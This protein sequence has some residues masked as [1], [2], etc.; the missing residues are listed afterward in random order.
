MLNANRSIAAY[1]SRGIAAFYEIGV[2]DGEDFEP[3][4]QG[5]GVPTQCSS[6]LTTCP[7]HCC[8]GH[9]ES[10]S[11]HRFRVIQMMTLEKQGTLLRSSCRNAEV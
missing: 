11:F 10:G 6:R 7:R 4:C 5:K 3:D 1:F 2:P 8:V 9:V